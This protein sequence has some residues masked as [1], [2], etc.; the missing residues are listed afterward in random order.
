MER[1][2][3]GCQGREKSLSGWPTPTWGCP[4]V[5]PFLLEGCWV[6]PSSL[7]LVR[8]GGN[9]RRSIVV[10]AFLL[11]GAAWYAAFQSAR[12]VVGILRRVQRLRNT[13]VFADPTFSAFFLFSFFYV[14]SC[15]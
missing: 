14:F 8:T 13:F 15:M 5:P 1:P 2:E 6:K 7:V 12:S 11:E 10:V 9:P 4:Q 3:Q